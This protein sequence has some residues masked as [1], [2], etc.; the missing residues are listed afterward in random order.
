MD[1]E[2][3]MSTQ[4]TIYRALNLT[5]TQTGDGRVLW[6]DAAT[7]KPAGSTRNGE[8]YEVAERYIQTNGVKHE[9]V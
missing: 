6:Y 9:R 7:M 3:E 5:G 8:G 1:S 2:V 4:V